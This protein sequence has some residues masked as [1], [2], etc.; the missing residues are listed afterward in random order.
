MAIRY[1]NTQR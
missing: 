1:L